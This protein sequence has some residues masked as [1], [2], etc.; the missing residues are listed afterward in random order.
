MDKLGMHDWITTT[1]PKRD[2]RLSVREITRL[3]W[4]AT[5]QR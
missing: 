1:D 2:I 4:Q 5:T 3:D